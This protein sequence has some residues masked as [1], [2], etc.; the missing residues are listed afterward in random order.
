VKN[1]MRSI[2][3][4]KIRC[5]FKYLLLSAVLASSLANPANVQVVLAPAVAEVR[6][7][8]IPSPLWQKFADTIFH[9]LSTQNGLPQS[10][11][12]AIAQD[13]DGFIWVGTQGGLARWDG[14][15]FRNYLP[16]PDDESS[17]PDHYVL[18]LYAD[19]RG[20]LWVST[21]GGGIAYY[22]NRLDRFVRIP[23]GAK[24]VSHVTVNGILGDGKNGLW[25]A[26]RAGLN[27][28]DPDTGKFQHFF[29]DPTQEH[30]LPS[31]F[32][33]SLAR[34]KTG[35]IWVGTSQ[36]LVKQEAADFGSSRF[37]PIRLP[38][39]ANKV[40]RIV[41]LACSQDG[42]IWVGTFDAGAFYIDPKE[43]IP[44]RLL[45]PQITTNQRLPA[46]DNIY[47]IRE[48]AENEI[49]LGTYG[50]GVVI[51]NGLTLEA[52]RL[53]SDPSRSTSLADNSIWS[54]FRDRSGLV[55]V[56]SQRGIS[57]HDPSASAFFTL[58]GSENQ[59]QGLVGI[60]FFSAQGLS[61]G[62]VWIGSQNHGI[63]ILRPGADRFQFLLADD[64]QPKTALPQSAI[65]M[66]FQS[67]TGAIY[68][69]TD[70]GLYRSD[71]SGTSVQKQNLT[72]R[73]PAMRVAAM[74][75]VSNK[76]LIGGP[77]GLWEKDLASDE[78]K[79]TQPDWAKAIAN[80]FITDIQ[81]APDG[82]LWVATSQE[83]IY[84][85]D[86][87]SG[88]LQNFKPDLK[89]SQTLSHRNVSNLLFD[90]RGWLWIAMQGGGV[91]VLKSPDG[92]A[93][94]TFKHLRKEQG[95]P[96]D[97]VNKV[98]ED[99]RGDIWVS[100][101]EG[102]AKIHPEQL[103]VTAITEPDGVAIT[104]YW[105][106]AGAK[107]PHGDLI[108]GGVGGLTI[109]RP[110][111]MKDYSFEPPVVIT[112][113]QAGGKTIAANQ[114]RFFGT[115]PEKLVIHPDAN[116]MIVEFAALD[117]SAPER[118]RYAYQLEGYDKTWIETDYTRRLA[119]YTNLAPGEYRLLL[120]G[121][122]R[123]GAW[124][125]TVVSLPIRVLPAWFQTWWAYALYLILISSLIIGLVRWRLWRLAKRNRT[126]ELL[127]QERTQELEVSRQLLEQQ[128][129]TDHLTGLRNR[130]FL[131][132]GM[133]EDI[134]L[135]NR[136][137][138]DL[139]PRGLNRAQRHLDIIFIM[140]D[141]DYFKSVNDEFG[142]AAGDSVLIETTQLL[143]EAVRESDTIIR[144]GGEEFL[145]VARNSN[146]VE[147]QVLAERIRTRIAEHDFVL[148]DGQILHKTCSLGVA[149]YPFIPN[150]ID[151]FTW[152]QV[153]DIAD[154]CLYAA[155]HGG[156]N[157]WVGLFLPES[158]DSKGHITPITHL[159]FDLEQQIAHGHIL[160]KTSLPADTPLDWS[161][162]RER[163]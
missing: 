83:G 19:P 38:M 46:N 72:P 90:S 162:G 11:A 159:A 22:D 25:L 69:G 152:E 89:N 93:T 101:D 148:P 18:S 74:L 30:S 129:L 78:D 54:I 50:K 88:A 142:H 140:V 14:Y 119:A 52:K 80:K 144:W 138:Q 62:S 75:E 32:I 128:S 110:S 153:I 149:A 114:N 65:F 20:R 126:L 137:Y 35:G 44:H 113:I 155:K 56:G 39:E 82:A 112:S 103:K 55:W 5:L 60:D 33:R 9:R 97:L 132:F 94:A 158:D 116:S 139:D 29:S 47:T 100:T 102:L 124:S 115:D 53:L 84:R 31:N 154:Q 73:N 109:V 37:K 127:V 7:G 8:P 28:Y 156:R 85:I 135:V 163:S 118:N 117:Y 145:I 105:S 40:Q 123:S 77:E 157:A 131:S 49:W 21:N 57:L 147:A 133:V 23:V 107:L 81:R 106:N 71:R 59:T 111:L 143:K 24:A 68:I 86:M 64:S 2:E 51:V 92:K 96:N 98:L 63:S 161:H 134:A 36:G 48:T 43:G 27:H 34:D 13:G 17:L 45:L 125:E 6:P 61:D 130:R 160:V 12:T 95:L 15:R 99:A 76:L 151:S 70:K 87:E 42:K 141:I 3:P 146:Y 66:I 104:G 121:S 4:S 150:S 79:A 26:T 67:R 122:N 108:F 136:A 120:R 91:D 16:I 1:L 10:S 58:Y 41:S